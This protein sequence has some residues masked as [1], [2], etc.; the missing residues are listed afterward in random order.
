MKYLK[1]NNPDRA[2]IKKAILTFKQNPKNRFYWNALKNEY[3]NI[4]KKDIRR[5]MPRERDLISSALAYMNQW[6]LINKVNTWIKDNKA[7]IINGFIMDADGNQSMNQYERMINKGFK[8]F[9]YS[10]PYHYGLYNPETLQ[11]F[12]YTEGDTSLINCKNKDIFLNEAKDTIKFFVDE[13]TELNTSFW[14][15]SI[16]TIMQEVNK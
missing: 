5:L 14:D 8:G 3:Q 13:G 6:D 1:L 10:A 2:T 12:T 16:K 7:E 4:L 11:F 15:T 9:Y